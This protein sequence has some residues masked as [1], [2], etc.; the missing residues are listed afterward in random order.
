MNKSLMLKANLLEKGINVSKDA[1]ELLD[2]KSKIWLMDDYITASGVSM[3]FEDQYVTTRADSESDI[4]LIV[5]DGDFY[6]KESDTEVKANV[7]IPPEYMEDKIIIGGKTITNYVNTYT[8]RIRIQPMC[9][10]KNHCK[11]CNARDYGYSFNEIKDIDEAFQIA[12][13]QS[14]ARHAFISTNNVKDVEGF[15]KLTKVFEYFAA[16]Y[17]EMGLDIMTSPRGFTS[18][19]DSSQYKP[20]LQHLK[21][22]GIH[23]IAVNMELNNPEKLKFYCPEKAEIGQERYLKFIEDAVEVFGVNYVRSAFIVG[24]EPLEET[25]KGVEKLAQRGCIPV[26]S[27]LYPYGEA[28]GDTSAK[29]FYEAR[30]KSEEICKK[31]GI[32]MGPLCNACAHNSI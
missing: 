6:I 8:D 19:T 2:T 28:Q 32:K 27:P 26:L 4:F 5:K 14:N 18:Y 7:I 11:F 16:K 12:L 3:Q 22:I 25:L 13:K 15:E 31:Y 30:T 17:P 9:G 20:Y 24:L 29:T 10:C 1:K 23:G 21:N